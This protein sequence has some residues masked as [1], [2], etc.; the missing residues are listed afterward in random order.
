MKTDLMN[1]RFIVKSMECGAMGQQSAK[2]ANQLATYDTHL[3]INNLPTVTNQAG[4]THI[5]PADKVTA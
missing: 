2:L 5:D 1:Q 3:R 4:C